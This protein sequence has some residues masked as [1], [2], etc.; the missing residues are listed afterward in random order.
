MAKRSS[1]I[2][3][4]T[5]WAALV[6]GGFAYEEFGLGYALLP[7]TLAAI[8]RGDRDKEVAQEIVQNRSTGVAAVAYYMI[9]LLG[10]LARPR[11]LG[12]THA[13]VLFCVLALPFVLLAVRNDILSC[14]GKS[15][16]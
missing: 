1:C 9:I 5:S 6:V 10:T 7:L 11:W 12:A 13:L 3:L 16:T 14:R 4:T 2:S 15:K 8:L